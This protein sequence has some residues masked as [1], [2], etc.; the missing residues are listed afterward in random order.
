MIWPAVSSRNRRGRGKEYWL[1][2]FRIR[3]RE[4]IEC[5]GQRG[6]LERRLLYVD[7]WRG[8]ADDVPVEAAYSRIICGKYSDEVPPLLLCCLC[9][10]RLDEI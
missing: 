9:G 6:R 5:K 1:L 2:I 8:S 7:I 3:G 4:A 10:Y